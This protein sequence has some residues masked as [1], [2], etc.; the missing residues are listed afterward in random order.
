MRRLLVAQIG[1]VTG[2]G[3]FARNRRPARVGNGDFARN[4]HPRRPD[5]LLLALVLVTLSITGCTTAEPQSD[6]LR[7]ANCGRTETSR[8]RRSAW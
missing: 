6:G 3:D 8:S 5:R 7:I 4:R 1:R 2:S